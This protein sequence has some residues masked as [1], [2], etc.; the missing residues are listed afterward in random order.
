MKIKHFNPYFNSEWCYVRGEVDH[1]QNK[2]INNLSI[3]LSWAARSLRYSWSPQSDGRGSFFA[4]WPSEA[5]PSLKLTANAPE[6]RPGPKRKRPRI[7]TIHFQMRLLLVSGSVEDLFGKNKMTWKNRR[8]RV[9]WRCKKNR[10]PSWNGYIE[11]VIICENIH[12]Y[13]HFEVAHHIDIYQTIYHLGY[14]TVSLSLSLYLWSIS[15]LPK[16]SSKHP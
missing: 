10:A 9:F 6:N 5:I 16:T 1:P 7:P 8:R 13:I 14:Q 12:Q 11:G 4:S 3:H 15:K 2:N